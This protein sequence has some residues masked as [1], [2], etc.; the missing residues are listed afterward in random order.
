MIHS[1][2]DEVLEAQLD[3]G[4]EIKARFFFAVH[5]DDPAAKFIA[6]EGTKDEGSRTF[7]FDLTDVK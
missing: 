7:A 6:R 4:Q 3:P 1:T 5:M 2:R